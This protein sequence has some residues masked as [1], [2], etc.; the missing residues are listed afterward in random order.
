VSAGVTAAQALEVQRRKVYFRKTHNGPSTCATPSPD[1]KIKGQPTITMH[2][3]WSGTVDVANTVC[4]GRGQ[5][6]FRAKRIQV[7]SDVRKSLQ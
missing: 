3:R 5:G 1:V 4:G 6:V 2:T 7:T